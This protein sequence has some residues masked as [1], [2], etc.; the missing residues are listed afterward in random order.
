MSDRNAPNEV[1]SPKGTVGYGEEADELVVQYEGVTFEEVHSDVLHLVPTLPGRILD[2]GAGTGR[3]AAALAG[4]GH[5]VVAVEPTR[6]LRAHG[7]RIHAGCGIDWVDDSLPGLVLGQHTGRFNAVFA[8]AVWMHLASEEREVAMARVAALLVPGGLFFIH[9]RHGPV[10]D[11]RHMFDVSAAETAEL[12]RRHGLWP[13]HRSERPDLHGRDSV[14]W[15]CLVLQTDDSSREL[16]PT[17][18]SSALLEIPQLDQN[19]TH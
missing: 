12:G 4:R 8:T 9:L 3:D 14:H 15:S 2:V 17:R 6:E 13:I 1:G 10:P 16:V 18:N 19:L 5:S 7:Q 11:Q